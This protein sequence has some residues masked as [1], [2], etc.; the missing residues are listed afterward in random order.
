MYLDKDAIL[1]SLTKEDI[2]KIV[3]YFG[4][5]Y[6]KTDSNGDLIFQSVCHGSDSWKLYYYHEPNEDK[7]YKGRT[8]HC[9][10]KCSDSFNVVEL[11][12]RANRV[13]GK[14]VTCIKRY[15]LLG[16]LQES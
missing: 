5:S 3:T 13:K 6:P 4:S 9:Y 1:N 14:T 7:G 15:I 2:I 8:F 16:N 11:V 10:S 12:I